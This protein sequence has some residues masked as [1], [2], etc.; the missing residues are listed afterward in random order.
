MNENLV[1]KRFSM[2]LVV[3]TAANPKR[4]DK[5][6]LVCLCDCGATVSVNARYLRD[7]RS[8]GCKKRV[9]VN[10]GLRNTPTYNTWYSMHERCRSPSNA[11][12]NHYGARGVRVCERWQTL[13]NFIA[14]MGMRPSGMTLD[15]ID[16]NGDYEPAN[17]RW[18]DAITQQ[19][20]RRSVVLT[21]ELVRQIR[22][23]SF[24]GMSNRKIAALI[25]C[26]PSTISRIK[27]GEAWR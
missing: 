19:R 24:A 5:P 22:D 7:N 27:S 18:A 20:N 10:V 23:G 17:C 11:S 25:G 12:W 3:G 2:L 15:R 1:G 6:L 8:C 4:A 14:D 16:S 9:D 13:A 21:N 26:D